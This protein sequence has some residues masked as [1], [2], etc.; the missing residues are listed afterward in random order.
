MTSS[1]SVLASNE[2]QHVRAALVF[3]G[4]LRGSCSNLQALVAQSRMCREAFDK[5]CDVFLH[6]W[7]TIH[8]DSTFKVHGSN[9]TDLLL[10]Q[11]ARSSVSS[12][13]PS[14][15]ACVATIARELAPAAVTVEEQALPSLEM[16]AAAQPWGAVRENLFN[17]RWQVASIHG[18]IEL[19]SRHAA[20]T[21][22]DYHAVV[23][24]RADVGERALPSRETFPTPASYA[25][26]R[27]RADLYVRGRLGH[28]AREVVTCGHPRFKMTVTAAG[29]RSTVL[30]V[31]AAAAALYPEVP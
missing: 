2:R 12:T 11:L 3:T 8:K 5:R 10:K 18:G 19:M 26:V 13:I 24:M 15:W 4:F 9:M 23:R 28:K 31:T 6:T 1:D 21:Q 14:S 7:S 17:F 25:T 29:A 27:R 20:A 30:W 22:T 16:A